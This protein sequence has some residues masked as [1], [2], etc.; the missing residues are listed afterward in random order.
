M[1]GCILGTRGGRHEEMIETQVGRGF[2]E[3]QMET[4]GFGDSEELYEFFKRYQ[5]RHEGIHRERPS[6]RKS[7]TL[8]T[9]LR[10]QPMHIHPRIGFRVARERGR[11]DKCF[12]VVFEPDQE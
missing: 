8:S 2:G 9:C 10:E 1:E 4:H 6:R 12:M 7:T 3:A 11:N 5:K